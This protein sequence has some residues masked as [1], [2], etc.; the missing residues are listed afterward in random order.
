MAKAKKRAKAKK[1]AK[2]KAKKVVK[3]KVKCAAKSKAGNP[4]RNY[5]DGRSKY[6]KLHQRKK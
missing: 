4:C 2:P 3:A 1:A 5:A 6:C